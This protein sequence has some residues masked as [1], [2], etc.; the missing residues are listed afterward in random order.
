M[1]FPSLM[2]VTN[3]L[4]QR[5]DIAQSGVGLVSVRYPEGNRAT[6][7]RTDDGLITHVHNVAKPDSGLA[8]T[9]IYVAYPDCAVEPV[10]CR[11]P[12]SMTDA[13]SGVTDYTYDAAGNL[14][15]ETGPAPTPG[16]PRPQTRSVWQQQYAWYK[17]GGSSAITRAA[18]PVWVRVEQSTCATAAPTPGC[19][20]GGRY[21]DHHRLSGQQRQRGQQPASGLDHLG[22]WNR[23]AQ[24]HHHHDL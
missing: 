23:H 10:L 2:W 20:G 15:T 17:Q 8:E 1:L 12:T 7:D 11:M 6:F 5:T 22:Q 4:G 13:R 9:N 14:L 18:T 19:D 16:A 24:R 21:P 3:A